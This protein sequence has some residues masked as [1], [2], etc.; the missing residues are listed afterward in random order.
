MMLMHSKES[1]EA[2][3]G[4]VKN[5]LAHVKAENIQK[6]NPPAVKPKSTSNLTACLDDFSV[7]D[8]EGF[9]KKKMQRRLE[10]S[11]CLTLPEISNSD[12]QLPTFVN[13][14]QINQTESTSSL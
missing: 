1:K 13:L 12:N 2:I 9:Y 7:I 11:V 14:V 8:P 10:K 6:F 5:K 3:I 4:S